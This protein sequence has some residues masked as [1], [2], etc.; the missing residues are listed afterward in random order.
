MVERSLQ[1]HLNFTHFVLTWCRYQIIILKKTC[2]I[3]PN[4]CKDSYVL[5]LPLKCTHDDSEREKIILQYFTSI[6]GILQIGGIHRKLGV[7]GLYGD[8]SWKLILKPRL[9][10]ISQ[11]FKFILRIIFPRNLFIIFSCTFIWGDLNVKIWID[12]IWVNVSKTET[13]LKWSEIINLA[14]SAAPYSSIHVSRS[15][16]DHLK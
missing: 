2:C 1:E 12:Y 5:L 11:N 15:L 6:Y 9:S 13:K 14:V 8:Y 10:I 3:F 7:I 16:Y 4:S